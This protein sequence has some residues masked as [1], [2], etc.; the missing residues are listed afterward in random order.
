MIKVRMDGIGRGIASVV[1]R[2][3]LVIGF[4][5]LHNLT[6]VNYIKHE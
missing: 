2:A 6:Q 5:T 3:Q 4:P 1:E